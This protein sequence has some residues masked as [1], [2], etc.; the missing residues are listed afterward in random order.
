MT[1]QCVFQN[2]KRKELVKKC[3]G[4]KD[5]IGDIRCNASSTEIAAKLC[6]FLS[7]PSS[8]DASLSDRIVMPGVFA[9]SKPE[10]P[11]SEYVPEVLDVVQRAPVTASEPYPPPLPVAPV[12]GI[13]VVERKLFYFVYGAATHDEIRSR[14]N[15][16]DVR[17]PELAT[18]TGYGLYFTGRSSKWGGAVASIAPRSGSSGVPGSLYLLSEA[19]LARLD[20]LETGH[21]KREIVVTKDGLRVKAVTHIPTYTQWIVMPSPQY[22]AAMRAQRDSVNVEDPIMIVDQFGTLRVY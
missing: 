6:A 21:S 5:K 22:I 15:S 18:A 17:S 16:I 14:T 11:P 19:E 20:D 9:T 4:M 12:P 2:M 7:G 1:P 8:L 3:M 13:S 10:L